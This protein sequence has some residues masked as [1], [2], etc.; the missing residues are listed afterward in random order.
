MELRFIPNIISVMHQNN[1][2]KLFG[3]KPILGQTYV[4]YVFMKTKNNTGK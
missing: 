1:V 4:F 2:K 3:L